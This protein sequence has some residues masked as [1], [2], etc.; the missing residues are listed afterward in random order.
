[1]VLRMVGFQ[2]WRRNLHVASDPVAVDAT[3]VKQDGTEAAPVTKAA[4]ASL[5][6]LAR[7]ARAKKPQAAPIRVMDPDGNSPS[8]GSQ[9]DPMNPPA[10]QK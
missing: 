7:A 9:R 2:S 10:P 8:S 4:E 3:L 1:M 6:D 5:G